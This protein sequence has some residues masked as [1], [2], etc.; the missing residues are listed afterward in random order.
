MEWCNGNYINININKTKFCIYGTRAKVATFEPNV[1]SSND[2]QI[3]RCS[4]YQY[5]GVILD[6][7]LTMKPNY[8]AIFKKFSYKIFRFAKL[9]KFLNTDTRIIVY[10]QTILPL[11][12]YVSFVMCLSNNHEVDKLQKLQNSALRMCYNINNPRDI[13]VQ[14]LNEMADIDTLYKRRMLQLLCILYDNRSLY[15][16][17]RIIPH[18]TRLATKRN[19]D[20]MR[21]NTDIYSRSP[22][23]IG[24]K[25]WNNLPKQTQDKK[26][27][28][29]FKLAISDLL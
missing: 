6:E 21:V 8:N 9:K 26:T 29:Q 23:C 1:L 28:K 22:F 7:C 19:F 10:K 25:F 16:Q 17:D 14:R 24:G 12:E 3:H 15:I 11:A 4:H 18:N 20:I 2:K 13:R 27:K 5:L